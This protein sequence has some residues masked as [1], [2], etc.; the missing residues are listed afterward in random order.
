MHTARPVESYK[1]APANMV[2]NSV[3]SF[4]ASDAPRSALLAGRTVHEARGA[5]AVSAAVM[6]WVSWLLGQPAL[7]VPIV[8]IGLLVCARRA[9]QHRT[10]P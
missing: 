1:A 9:E 4:S 10:Q 8:G 2:M 3:S 7:L 5:R 6:P